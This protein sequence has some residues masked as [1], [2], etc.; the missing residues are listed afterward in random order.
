MSACRGARDRLT[1]PEGHTTVKHEG[2]HRKKRVRKFVRTRRQGA[3]TK[4][5]FPVSTIVF[6]ANVHRFTLEFFPLAAR[7]QARRFDSLKATQPAVYSK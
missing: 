3:L 4:L 1:L 5:N 2:E 7:I 6:I